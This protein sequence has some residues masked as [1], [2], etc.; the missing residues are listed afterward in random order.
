MNQSGLN[1]LKGHNKTPWKTIPFTVHLSLFPCIHS[2][3]V[4]SIGSSVAH[5]LSSQAI[6]NVA[7]TKV[8][9][10]IST[11][12]LQK[13]KREVFKTPEVIYHLNSRPFRYI[14]SLL[15]AGSFF[16]MF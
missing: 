9:F 7:V 2:I 15:A 12:T 1:L 3:S 8:A 13:P 4:Y 14:S 10:T 16:F 11:G 6:L 5:S